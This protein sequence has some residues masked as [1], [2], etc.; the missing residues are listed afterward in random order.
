MAVDTKQKRMSAINVY[1]PYRG[2]MVDP[3]AAWAQAG[4]Q[5]AAYMYS[6]I[7]AA[8][9]TA[10]TGSGIQFIGEI[11]QISTGGIMNTSMGQG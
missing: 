7:L 11:Q 3:A 9:S 1:A 4:R 6:G 5:A 8:A 2:T 10:V